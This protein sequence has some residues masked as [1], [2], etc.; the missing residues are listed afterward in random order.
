MPIA[1]DDPRIA[2]AST[3]FVIYNHT[4]LNAARQFLLDFGLEL[5]HESQDGKELFFKGYG[6]EPFIYIA[7]QSSSNTFGG[8]RRTKFE[9]R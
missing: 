8:A 3:A 9:S 7:R 5:T 2:L 4:N 1:P 6:T